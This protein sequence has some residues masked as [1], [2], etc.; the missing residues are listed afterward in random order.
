MRDTCFYRRKKKEWIF[1]PQAARQALSAD[2]R[3]CRWNQSTRNGGIISVQS[4]GLL[5]RCLVERA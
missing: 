5:S 2:K 1:R 4:D 3:N